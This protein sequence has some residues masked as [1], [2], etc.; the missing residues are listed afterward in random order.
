MQDSSIT[1]LEMAL[2]ERR[3]V[4]VME[5]NVKMTI[6]V[7]VWKWPIID[8]TLCNVVMK[9]IKLFKKDKN[10]DLLVTDGKFWLK[11]KLSVSALGTKSVREEDEIAS[12]PPKGFYIHDSRQVPSSGKLLP[13]D[14]PWSP[15]HYRCSSWITAQKKMNNLNKAKNEM[16]WS[17]ETGILN[18]KWNEILHEKNIQQRKNHPKNNS[19]RPI[20]NKN[21]S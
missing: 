7:F 15:Q 13:P 21:G 8:P 16:K 20:Q 19:K 9:Q 1:K 10:L 6:S 12:S 18:Q 4:I 11:F 2:T 14:P 5:K 17:L 3:N